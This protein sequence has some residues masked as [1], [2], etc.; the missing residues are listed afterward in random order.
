[1]ITY[2]QAKLRNEIKIKEHQIHTC[3][4]I[5]RALWVFFKGSKHLLI[6][7]SF[8]P[9][10]KLVEGEGAAGGARGGDPN[11]GEG[12][13]TRI[14]DISR[15]GGGEGGQKGGGKIKIDASKRIN[16]R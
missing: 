6:L 11:E 9:C 7:S 4:Q 2:Q 1:M 15:E 10:N 3:F 14:I 12:V 13:S 5:S 8:Y 16:N